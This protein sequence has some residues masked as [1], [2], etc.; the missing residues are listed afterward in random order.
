VQEYNTLVTVTLQVYYN[1]YI[2]QAHIAHVPSRPHYVNKE[3]RVEPPLRGLGPLLTALALVA[4]D[5]HM[6]HLLLLEV[7]VHRRGETSGSA[8]IRRVARPVREVLGFVRVD[9]VLAQ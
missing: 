3:G 2:V 1:K 7:L 5:S 8:D 6:I 4:Q 9:P